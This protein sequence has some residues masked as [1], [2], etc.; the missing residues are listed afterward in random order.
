MVKIKSLL[1]LVV[2]I[3][4]AIFLYSKL[5]K[6]SKKIHYHAG[7][8][9]Y[10]DDVLQD[11]SDIKYMTI[12]PCTDKKTHESKNKELEKAHLH[13]QV[14]DV[15]HVEVERSIWGNL[16]KNLHYETAFKEKVKAY[17]NRRLIS[18]PLSYSIKPYDS[19]VF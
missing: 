12:S 14:G 7:F 3:A 15:V 10:K 5:L 2:F 19:I 18:D 13:D 16:F 6:T 1:F 11:F 8:Q 9:V 17:T 4:L